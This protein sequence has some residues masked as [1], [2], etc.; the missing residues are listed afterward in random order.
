[1]NRVYNEIKK[2]KIIRKYDRKIMYLEFSH[3]STVV[4][5]TDLPIDCRTLLCEHRVNRILALIETLFRF[6]ELH[7][8][9][10]CEKLNKTSLHTPFSFS[11]IMVIHVCDE[12]KNRE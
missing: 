9:N 4:R 10:Y 11:P 8:F 6:P 1:M 12:A 5:G 7:G 2:Q 3:T